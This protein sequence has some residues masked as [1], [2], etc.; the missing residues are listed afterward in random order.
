MKRD[1]GWELTV[2][3]RAGAPDGQLVAVRR[4]LY[5][6][7]R[8]AP[9]YTV[10]NQPESLL[11]LAGVERPTAELSALGQDETVL[12]SGGPHLSAGGS[13]GMGHRL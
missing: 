3:R 1:D 13:A 11:I 10:V 8:R 5:G 2:P 6:E 9:L 12:E 4:C 7:G